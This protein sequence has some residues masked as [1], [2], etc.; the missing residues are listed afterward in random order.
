MEI[1][2]ENTGAAVRAGA[3]RMVVLAADASENARARAEGFLNGRRALLVPLPYTKSEL[4]AM[5]GKS[6]CSMAAC[7]DFGLSA[8]FL[9]ALSEN[10]PDG[11]YV[12]LEAQ[13]CEKEIGEGTP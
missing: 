9:A 6:G 2:E 3:A 8:A 4:S 13:R 11:R 7:T 5:L 10:S 12:E 1:G